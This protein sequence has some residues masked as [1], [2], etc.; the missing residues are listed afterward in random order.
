MLRGQCGALRWLRCVLTLRPPSAVPQV[1]QEVV[2]ACLFLDRNHPAA[3]VIIITG[4]GAVKASP[5]ACCA[6]PRQPVPG[7]D[8]ADAHR[9]SGWLSA[10]L[11]AEL[12]PSG[13]HLASPR[14]HE[15]VRRQG[16][17]CRCRHQGNGRG[18]L[19]RGVQYLPAQRLGDA[20]Q[21]G[22]AAG[23]GCRGGRRQGGAFRSI[24]ELVSLACCPGPPC[25]LC[26][27]LQS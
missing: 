19:C 15:P 10:A 2:S 4:S 13:P 20:A 22:T 17:C 9:L 23:Q 21:V 3:R 1:M 25:C 7:I 6:Q 12:T 27:C 24:V 26:V 16:F 11:L 14:C 8:D 5:N 18:G